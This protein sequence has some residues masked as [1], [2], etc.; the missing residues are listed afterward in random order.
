[1]N[2]NPKL[3][4]PSIFIALFTLLISLTVLA[5]EVDK[6]ANLPKT[7]KWSTADHAKFPILN[8]P[9]ET[10]AQVTQACISC[11]VEAEEQLK[12][13]IHWTWLS[14]FDDTGE[15]GKAGYSVN[16]FCISTNKMQDV[17][18]SNCHIGWNGKN[19][20]INCMK[21]HSKKDIHWNDVFKD[22]KSFKESGDTEIASDIQK[23]IQEAVQNVGLPLRQNCGA[24]HFNGGGGEAVKHGDLDNSL[25][26][27]KKELDV[28]MGID[29]QDF[30]CTR[31][32]TTIAHQ[33]AGRVYSTPASIQR[34]S[35]VDNDLVPKIMCES[36]H[37]T[38]PHK[39][40]HKANDHTD[41]VACQAC[42]IPQFAREHPTEMWWDWS[43]A[44][45]LKDGKHY[46][47]K[48]E[49]D[50]FIYKTHKGEFKWAQNVVPEY[51]WYNG[52][53]RTL[54]LKDKINPTD[55]PVRV[56]WPV[57]NRNDKNSRIFPFKIHRGK[58]PYDIKNNNLLAPLLSEEVDGYWKTLNWQDSINRGMAIMDLPYSGEMDFVE[59]AYVYPT[60][61]TV[62]P[63]NGALE[64][65]ACHV[66]TKSRLTNLAG[67]YMPGRDHFK[68]IDLGGWGI[69]LAALVSVFIHAMGRKFFNAKKKED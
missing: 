15:T 24:C 58:Q 14:P 43:K 64:C 2:F 49:F 37:T 3:L 53:I 12:K 56:S 17:E 62:V 4:T 50:R 6:K 18:C 31:C 8:Q 5:T 9:F 33:I 1:V 61:H 46:Q 68:L 27:P 10:G 22:Y 11:H 59:T 36:C 39:H 29:S 67:F 55:M 7:E 45:K 35:L 66:R 47:E 41:K 30:R 28:H 51:Y 42:H 65:T 19:S 25:V 63:K 48:G 13:T 32:H 16:N 26:S 57:G 34:Q 44:G 38:K 54:T 23:T 20:S 21:C 52:S 40:G 69:S 60:T